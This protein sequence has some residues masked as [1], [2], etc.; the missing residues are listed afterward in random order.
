M[1]FLGWVENVASARSAIFCLSLS[2]ACH[3]C[4]IPEADVRRENLAIECRNNA[5]LGSDADGY[6]SEF[7]Q[8]I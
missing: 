3:H 5:F 6:W 1:Q 2:G 8:A 4:A 7:G